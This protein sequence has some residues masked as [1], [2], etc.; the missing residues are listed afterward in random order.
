M[1]ADNPGCVA[2]TV[3]GSDSG[4]GAGIQADLNTF[5]AFG[6][7]GTSA[8]T[9]ITAQNPDRI[10][11]LQAIDPRIVGAQMECVLA[12]FRVGGAKTGM[13]YDAEIVET[14]AY[15]F[16]KHAFK[17]LVVDPVMLASSGALLLK[18]DA[19]SAVKIKLLPR[20]AVVTPNLAEAEVLWQRKIRTLDE[21]R[22]AA[23]VLAERFEVPFLTKGGHLLQ[24]KR[25]VDVL[26]DGKEFHEFSASVVPNAKTHGTGCAFSA[27]IAANLALGHGLVESIGRAK[28][29]VTRAIR[30]AIRIGRYRALKI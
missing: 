6:V 17:P 27:A 25:A 7:F 2:L 1:K 20:A 9:C 18:K 24:A 26:F 23:R 30:D 21:L 3:A 28:K 16:R 11:A 4:G 22:E 15:V 29:F 12:A 10:T 19:F 14:V 5:R 13:L 8:L